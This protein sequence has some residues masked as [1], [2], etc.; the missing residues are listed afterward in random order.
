MG[1]LQEP[2]RLLGVEKVRCRAH[3]LQRMGD[4]ECPSER[5]FAKLP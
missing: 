3:P 2:E 4:R 1:L 5:V